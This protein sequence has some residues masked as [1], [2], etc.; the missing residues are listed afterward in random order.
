[1]W[2]RCLFIRRSRHL[3]L[4]KAGMNLLM[5]A[6]SVIPRECP[7]DVPEQDFA[8]MKA[9]KTRRIQITVEFHT[10]FEWR[11]PIPED[12][13]SGLLITCPVNKTRLDVFTRLLLPAGV[14]PETIRQVKM[15]TT[16]MLIAVSGRGVSVL[17]DRMIDDQKH[18]QKHVY[19]SLAKP[20]AEKGLTRKF[21]TL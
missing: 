8:D 5:P 9:G 3:R 6:N 20:S 14:A 16:I 4:S 21:F 11:F 10:C 15:A 2:G 1:M 19:D 18:G 12:F 13:R 17:P 7:G